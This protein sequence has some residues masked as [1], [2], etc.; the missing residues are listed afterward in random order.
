MSYLWMGSS[1]FLAA[2]LVVPEEI[3]SVRGSKEDGE[4]HCFGY[5]RQ[6][7]CHHIAEASGKRLGLGVLIDGKAQS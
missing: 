5:L 2:A 7:Q 4:H 3:N 6:C 1:R